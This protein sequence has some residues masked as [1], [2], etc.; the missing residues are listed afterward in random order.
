MRRRFY[1]PAPLH[2]LHISLQPFGVPPLCCRK[3]SPQTGTAGV[4]HQPR[5]LGL[6]VGWPDRRGR[7]GRYETGVEGRGGW[8]VGPGGGAGWQPHWCLRGSGGAVESGMNGPLSASSGAG[9]HKKAK[10]SSLQKPRQVN[11][12]LMNAWKETEVLKNK[13]RHLIYEK[14]L[15]S[16][17]SSTVC[18]K[19]Q[20]GKAQGARTGHFFSPD[21]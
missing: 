13:D 11:L 10:D 2:F 5:L 1:V 15:K 16:Q 14:V 19:A 6:A 17:G 18:Q 21:D 4:T 3:R 8:T 20:P 12:K 9:C 7:T